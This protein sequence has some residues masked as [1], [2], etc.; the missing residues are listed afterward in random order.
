[1]KTSHPQK[2]THL[3]SKISNILTFPHY[4]I[5]K[6]FSFS[7]VLSSA[8][9]FYLTRNW[10]YF[11]QIVSLAVAFVLFPSQFNLVRAHP[12]ALQIYRLLRLLGPN[13]SK[14]LQ[15]WWPMLPYCAKS[16]KV[17]HRP[18]VPV[19]GG[20]TALLEVSGR[21]QFLIFWKYFVAS[22]FNVYLR[23][24]SHRIILG[25]FWHRLVNSLVF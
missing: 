16:I 1:M 18:S 11:M 12:L 13:T 23:Y 19:N 9:S 24:K 15:C 7:M 8:V 4:F 10:R 3:F 14:A 20:E 17:C 22:F 2:R 25:L 6:M 5:R 21:L